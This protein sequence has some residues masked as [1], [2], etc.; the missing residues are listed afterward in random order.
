MPPIDKKKFA[1]AKAKH[2]AADR[3]RR[4]S[5]RI[6]DSILS[7]PKTHEVLTNSD[8]EK[9]LEARSLLTLTVGNLE[10]EARDLKN[11]ARG[12]MI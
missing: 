10:S 4:A 9:I 6:T 3:V 12:G 11:E 1:E 5:Y 7:D 2:R 8:R